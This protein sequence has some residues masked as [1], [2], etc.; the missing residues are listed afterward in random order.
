MKKLIFLLLAL[1][2]LAAAQEKP[3]QVPNACEE[4]TPFTIR[5]PVRF[6]DNMTV[7]YAWYRND[8]LVEDSHTLLLG[9]KTIAYTIPAEDAFG[10]AVY[11]FTYRLNDGYNEWTRS[12]RYA[13]SFIPA[14]NPGVISYAEYVC[15]GIT[16][17]G[18]V[19]YAEYVCDGITDAGAVGY[20]LCNGVN[21]AG[22]VSAITNTCNGVSDAGTVGYALCN[23]INDAGSIS[24]ITHTCN[25]VNDAGTVSYA[26]YVCNGI[27]DAGTISWAVNN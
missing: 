9:E 24:V 27:T 7:Q 22:S 3:V 11:H 17:A 8:T 23:G 18:T 16:D 20:T 6:D 5:I 19:S 26:E 1:P 4:G 10:S 13:V 12:P 15:D 2:T 21:D 25:G 14:C